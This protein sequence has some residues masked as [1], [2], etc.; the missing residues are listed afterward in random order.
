MGDRGCMVARET[1]SEGGGGREA[2]GKRWLADKIRVRNRGA[3][4]CGNVSP[5]SDT[6][7][8]L[9]PRFF[10]KTLLFGLTLELEQTLLSSSSTISFHRMAIRYSG[11]SNYISVCIV[12]C[13]L[14]FVRST[15]SRVTQRCNLGLT[16]TGRY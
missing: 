11:I 7:P 2:R 5:P 12:Y 4:G 14:G 13:R 16:A 6:R 10:A 3:S 8:L 9:P 15:H 1:A